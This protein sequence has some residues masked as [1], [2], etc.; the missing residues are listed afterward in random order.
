MQCQIDQKAHHG[1]LILSPS[2]SRKKTNK[3]HESALLAG[4][5]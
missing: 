1:S 3:E 2:L 5:Y 4:K